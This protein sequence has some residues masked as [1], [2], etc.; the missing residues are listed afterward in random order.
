MTAKKKYPKT[1]KK[2]AKKNKDTGTKPV[3]STVD[4]YIKTIATRPANGTISGVKIDPEKTWLVEGINL[5]LFPAETVH[6]LEDG[7][8]IVFHRCTFSSVTILYFLSDA[9]LIDCTV[10]DCT[11]IS[12]TASLRVVKSQFSRIRYFVGTEGPNSSI[13]LDGVNVPS[14][15]SDV[16]IRGFAK[17]TFGE[18]ARIPDVYFTGCREISFDGVKHAHA[19]DVDYFRIFHDDHAP[20]FDPF[21]PKK[22]DKS[23][24]SISFKNC[25]LKRRLYVDMDSAR[26]A[27]SCQDSK[28]KQVELDNGTVDGIAM[29]PD[30]EIGI[31]IA[32]NCHFENKIDTTRV[33]LFPTRCT[34]HAECREITLYKKVYYY[35]WYKAPFA[36]SRKTYGSPIIA[37]LTVPSDADRHHSSDCKKI[38][39]AKA[40]VAGFY[41]YDPNTYE[42]VPFKPGPLSTVRA[43]YDRT[44]VYSLG[45]TVIPKHGFCEGTETCAAGIH[46]FLEPNEAIDY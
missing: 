32:A 28:L 41:T 10:T 2:Y 4:E 18:Q 39:V 35:P 12:T 45:A 1:V 19:P 44:F 20:H 27:I 25:I 26:T 29:S 38:R 5:H 9:V 22:E 14:Y 7:G 31:L 15:I 42:M 16:R 30:S 21:P 23:T 8:T 43:S 37:K 40:I 17:V 6:P 13:E 3:R 11:H 33:N 24:H 36:S 46:G 34:G